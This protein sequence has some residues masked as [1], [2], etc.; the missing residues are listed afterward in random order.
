MP[1]IDPESLRI[2]L[3][4]D[5]LTSFRGGEKVLLQLVRMFPRARIATLLH[6]AGTTHPEI[7]GR[8]ARTSFLQ[9]MPLARMHYRHY[10]PLFPRAIGSLK[11]DAEADLVL[12][13]SHAVAKGIVPPERPD[14]RRIPHICYCNSPMRY[15]WGQQNQYGSRR[16][17][18]RLA[19]KLI[20]PSLRRF[21]LRNETIAL[22]LA[23][24]HNIAGRI[25]R[26]YDRD[27]VVVYPGVD[28]TFAESRDV[29]AHAHAA[30]L[31]LSPYYLCAGALVPY[32]RVDLAIGAFVPQDGQPVRRLVI[33]GT[34]PE[35]PRLRR[36]A[37]NAP[38]IGFLGRISDEALL[39]CYGAARAFIFP[40][41][42]DFGLT[43]LEAQGA[44]TPVIAYAAGGALETVSDSAENRTGFFFKSQTSESLRGAIEQF[45]AS[46]PLSKPMLQRSAQRF[47]WEA[48]RRGILEAID[49]TL[50]ETGG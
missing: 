41:E 18:N 23:N 37:K 3:V 43:P 16:S 25:R 34:G 50:N 20:A 45:E 9:K 22:F 49:R 27:A 21:D 4:H 8:V 42:E 30:A 5:W 48:F 35:L 26:C 38:N 44:G 36:L 1:R 28:P 31:P 33:A 6:I 15:I 29:P 39:S 2:W 10:L 17:L 40:G 46:P 7:D 47:S 12:S 14:G 19:L 32:K 11:L 24:S 13:V